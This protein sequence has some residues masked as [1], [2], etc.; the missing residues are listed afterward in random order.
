[1]EQHVLNPFNKIDLSRLTV[2]AAITLADKLLFGDVS[3]AGKQ[4]RTITVQQFLEAM[5]PA[6]LR[7]ASLVAEAGI[8]LTDHLVFVD[9]SAADPKER[10]ITLEQLLAVIAPVITVTAT[11]S[12]TPTGMITAFAGVAAPSG[13]L[14]AS[15][16]TIGNDASGATARANADTQALYTLLWGA[17]GNAQLP[18]QDETGTPGVRGLSAAIDFAAGYR[19]PLLDLR[20]RVIVGRDN[21]GGTTANRITAAGSGIDGTVNGASGGD[22]AITLT[23]AELPAHT[24]DTMVPG[25]TSAA[26]QGGATISHP[27]ALAPVTSTST[28]DGEPFGIV[29][30]TLIT[31]YIIKL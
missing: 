12:I 31:N 9:N 6:N 3:A 26:G 25:T 20:G 2:E 8:I 30:P 29:Q 22:Q 5:F 19:L 23:E 24:H 13:W 4:E 28:G 1:M 15:G 27:A 17:Y 11:P 10:K 7:L 14:L 18:I 21:M 16:L